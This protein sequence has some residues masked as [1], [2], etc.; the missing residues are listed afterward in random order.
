MT[1]SFGLAVVGG[2]DQLV[3]IRCGSQVGSGARPIAPV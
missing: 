3:L 2:S 1:D